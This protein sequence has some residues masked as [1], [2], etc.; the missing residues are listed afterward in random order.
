MIEHCVMHI[1][2]KVNINYGIE[3]LKNKVRIESS[4]Y[5]GEYPLVIL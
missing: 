5:E 4:T 1:L 2:F 3:E